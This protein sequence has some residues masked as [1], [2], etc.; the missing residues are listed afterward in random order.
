MLLAEDGNKKIPR[1]LTGDLR[2]IE[3]NDLL[4]FRF[5]LRK[6]IHI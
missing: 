4:L 3:V 2:F 1:K 5:G 6:F